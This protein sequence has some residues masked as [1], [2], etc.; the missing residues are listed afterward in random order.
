MITPSAVW[1][2]TSSTVPMAREPGGARI[3]KHSLVISGHQTSVSL[4]EAFWRR[5][6][7]IAAEQTVSVNALAA[8]VDSDRGEANLSSA[9]RVFVLETLAASVVGRQKSVGC[10]PVSQ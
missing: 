3:G 5:L 6:Q 1:T 10:N 9:L 2:P 8:Y 7:A 4:E